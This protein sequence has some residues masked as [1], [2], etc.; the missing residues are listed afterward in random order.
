M[1]NDFTF[2]SPEELGLDS[3]FVL[4]FLE[5]MREYKVNLHSFMLARKG[6]ILTEA[7]YKPFHKDFAHRIYSSSKTYVSI[8]VGMLIGEGRLGLNDKLVDYFPEY[9]DREQHKW[10]QECTVEDALNWLLAEVDNV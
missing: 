9:M 1:I 4:Q 3:K 5:R 8:A 7:Y 2:K 10:M 6:D